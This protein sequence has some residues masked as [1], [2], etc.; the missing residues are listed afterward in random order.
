ME[1]NLI[2]YPTL[3]NVILVFLLYTKNTLD[4]RKAVKSKSL[5]MSYFKVYNGK[6]PDYVAVSRQTLKNQFELPMLFYFLI[7]IILYFDQVFLIDLFFAW[8]FV[9]SRYLHAYIR[10]SSNKIK[11]RSIIFQIGFYTLLFWFLKFSYNIF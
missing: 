8:L 10:L 1:K 6:V 9:I 11:H 7:S 5:K 3:L 2:I 4:N